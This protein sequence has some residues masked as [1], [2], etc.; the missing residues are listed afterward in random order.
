MAAGYLLIGAGFSLNAFA[1]SVPGLVACVVIFTFGEMVAMPVST[2][3]VAE[4]APAHLR[5]RYMGVYSLTWSAALV[6][7]P[8]LGLRIFGVAP[9]A[10]WLTCGAL[11]LLA[12]AIIVPL[13]RIG[14]DNVNETSV[15]SASQSRREKKGPP[16]PVSPRFQGNPRL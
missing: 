6:C 8:Q 4:L 3:Y 2:A 11:G 5:G 10:L 16:G 1:H 12:A 7:A 13:S 15:R 9:A 14:G